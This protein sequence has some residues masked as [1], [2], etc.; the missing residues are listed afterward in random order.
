MGGRQDH[1]GQVGELINLIHGFNRCAAFQFYS[2]L[3]PWQA[4]IF[5]CRLNV[6]RLVTQTMKQAKRFD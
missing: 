1:L 5:G 2:Q 6:G 4:S 3:I